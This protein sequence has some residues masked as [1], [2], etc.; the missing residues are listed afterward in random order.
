MHVVSCAH[1]H[2]S[3]LEHSFGFKIS[4][5]LRVRLCSKFV[6]KLSFKILQHTKCFDK[7]PYEILVFKSRS[8]SK[9]PFSVA[10]V[11]G[12]FPIFSSHGTSPSD[13]SNE[14]VVGIMVIS[15]VFIAISL[16]R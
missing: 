11:I 12:Q 5:C 2:I 10:N 14:T 9:I 3:D 15:G 6:T 4:W 1:F 16:N 7:P 13:S 8:T